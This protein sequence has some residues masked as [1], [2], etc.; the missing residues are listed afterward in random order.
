MLVAENTVAVVGPRVV[1]PVTVNKLLLILPVTVMLVAE[2]TVAVVGPRVVC[3]VTFS[4]LFT[5]AGLFAVKFP[6]S[7]VGPYIVV[8]DPTIKLAPI[9]APPLTCKTFV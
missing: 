9:A 6:N 7:T 5:V 3:P 1:C 8:V 4:V 2:N